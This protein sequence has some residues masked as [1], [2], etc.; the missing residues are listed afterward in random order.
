MTSS[1]VRST[2]GYDVA[3]TGRADP[4]GMIEA[5]RVAVCLVEAGTKAR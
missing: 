2:T 4:R 5:I 1:A 3:A